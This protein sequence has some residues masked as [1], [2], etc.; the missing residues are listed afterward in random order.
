MFSPESFDLTNGAVLLRL[1][2][3]LFLVPHMYFKAVGNPPPASKTFIEAGYP[4]PLL[5]VRFALV[6]EIIIATALFFDFYTQYAALV[7]AVL[8]VVAAVTVFFSNDKKWVW[9]WVKGGKEYSVF[10]ACV[11]VSLSMLYWQ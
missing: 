10:W 4:K 7:L 9:I 8:L 2:C 11:C 6:V 1:I 5:F 3:A